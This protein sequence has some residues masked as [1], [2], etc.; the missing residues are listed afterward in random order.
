MR[1]KIKYVLTMLIIGLV[2]LGLGYLFIPT[3][4]GANVDSLQTEFGST[5]SGS[6]VGLGIVNKKIT[7]AYSY[8]APGYKRIETFPVNGAVFNSSADYFCAQ[9]GTAYGAKR[10]TILGSAYHKTH[11]ITKHKVDSA[12]TK[13]EAEIPYLDIDTSAAIYLDENGVIQKNLSVYDGYREST[14][15]PADTV[16]TNWVYIPHNVAFDCETRKAN[17][18]VRQGNGDFSDGAMAFLLARYKQSDGERAS[19][20]YTSDPL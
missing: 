8:K 5:I 16:Y 4:I 11:T 15:T 12:S 2:L 7:K 10:N 19:T 18:G 1:E 14:E 13:N 17:I 6:P 3:T 9:H 20:G